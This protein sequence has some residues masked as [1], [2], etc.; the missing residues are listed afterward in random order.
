MLVSKKASLFWEL[1][2]GVLVIPENPFKATGFILGLLAIIR[3]QPA[4]LHTVPCRLGLW[5]QSISHKSLL[6]REEITT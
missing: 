6:N 3:P 2:P 5:T 1:S 4:E